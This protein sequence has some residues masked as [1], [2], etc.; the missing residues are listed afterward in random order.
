MSGRSDRL[1]RLTLQ[2]H[3]VDSLVTSRPYDDVTSA[4]RT[5]HC[6]LCDSPSGDPFVQTWEEHRAS[7]VVHCWMCGI[8]WRMGP[9]PDGSL[10]V[11][12]TERLHGLAMIHTLNP[13]P[14]ADRL[15]D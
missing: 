8:R 7:H 10:W 5:G 9:N 13:P 12:H 11:E 1:A 14:E 3:H 2:G 15:H 6:P 4:I